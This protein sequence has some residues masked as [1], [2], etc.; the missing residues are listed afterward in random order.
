M[1]LVNASTG[2]VLA[3]KLE[4]ADSF[5]KRLKG[6]MFKKSMPENYALHLTPCRSIHTFFMKFPIDVLY[7]D[8]EK[9]IVGIE[10]KLQPGKI[11]K[12]V[13][14][15]RT[16]IELPEGQISRTGTK[17]GQIV[18]SRTKNSVENSLLG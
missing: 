6:L 14:G 15:A 13:K 10:E 3:D 8:N 12:K 1:E 4:E 5:G 17:V 7:L 18:Q 2:E 11:G 16:V 9:T